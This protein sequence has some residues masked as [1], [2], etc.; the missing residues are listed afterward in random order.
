MNKIM[1]GD[2]LEKLKDLPD[3]SVDSYRDCETGFPVAIRLSLS[4][5]Q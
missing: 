3:N 5:S 1:H 2:C 4:V